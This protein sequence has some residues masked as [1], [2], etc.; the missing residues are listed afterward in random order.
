MRDLPQITCDAILDRQGCSH[1]DIV[2]PAVAHQDIMPPIPWGGLLARGPRTPDTIPAPDPRRHPCRRLR[3]TGPPHAAAY[4][5]PV[6]GQ[7]RPPQAHGE[8]DPPL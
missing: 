6:P 5:L 3:T 2:A 7:P 8:T 4:G 1:G